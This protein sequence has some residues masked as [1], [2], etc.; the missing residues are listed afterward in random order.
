MLY[1]WIFPYNTL[2]KL[3]IYIGIMI[4]FLV[5]YL[6][7][8]K[9]YVLKGCC[10]RIFIAA[11]FILSKNWKKPRYSW[12]GECINKL[13]IYTMEYHWAMEINYSNMQQHAW[14]SKTLCW[15]NLY[16]LVYTEW[17]LLDEVLEHTQLLLV[18]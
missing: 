10:R 17:F 9:T 7:E 12:T 8:I 2:K 18:T 16:N 15:V 6:R 14:I 4:I 1:I 5:I 13:H 11:L 3:H